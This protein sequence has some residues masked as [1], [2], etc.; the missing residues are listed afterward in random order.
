MSDL[1]WWDE[2]MNSM[3]QEEDADEFGPLDDQ[4][5]DGW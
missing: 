4:H 5:G 1:W 2:S 3:T